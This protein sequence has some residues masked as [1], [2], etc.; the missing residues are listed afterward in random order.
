MKPK[1]DEASVRWFH[2]KAS[3]PTPEQTQATNSRWFERLT[4]PQQRAVLEQHYLRA[5]QRPRCESCRQFVVIP[6]EPG[7][8]WDQPNELRCDLGGFSV[9]RD[10]VCDRW[11]PIRSDHNPE[12]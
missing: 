3:R 4:R 1:S 10:G 12:E 5:T 6:K 9:N 7:T 11:D 8:S 2:R